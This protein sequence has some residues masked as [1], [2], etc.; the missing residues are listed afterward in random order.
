MKMMIALQ[1]KDFFSSIHLESDLYAAESPLWVDAL[2]AQQQPGA[3]VKAAPG[4][5]W[6]RKK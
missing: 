5:V 3:V 6:D 1:V 2:L 4:A